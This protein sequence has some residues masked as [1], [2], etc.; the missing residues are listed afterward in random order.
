MDPKQAYERKRDR[1]A[2]QLKQSANQP[3]ALD[4]TTS[5]L[6][7]NREGSPR[8]KLNVRDFNS[9][10]NINVSEQTVEVEGMTTYED[11]VA[12]TLKQGSMPAVVPQLKTI[13]IG[14][15][16][17]GIGIEASSF[18]YGLAHEA[19]L[20]M[21]VLTASGEVLT[22]TPTNEH[23]DLF[24]AL[25]NSYG[26][27]GYIL[28]L[29]VKTVPVKPY[30]RIKHIKHTNSEEY[31]ADIAKQLDTD[32]DF[33][34]GSIFSP[35]EM[36]ITV[37]KFVGE[38]PY[39]SDYTF[40]HIYYRSIQ[41]RDEDYLSTHDFIWR[42]DTDWFW[43]SKHFYVENPLVRR[44][45]GRDRLNSRTYTK[46]MRWNQ[47]WHLTDKI[48]K[49]LNQHTESVIQDVDVPI[50]KA[51]EFLKFLQ[52]TIRIKPIWMCPIRASNPE[53]NF[54][55]YTINKN[56]T[57]I[58]F[59]FWDTIK[60]KKELPEGYYNKQIEDKLAEI[61]GIKSLYSESFYDRET[62][63]D[64]YNGDEYHALKKKYDPNGTFLGLYEKTVLRK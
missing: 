54:K 25:P 19:V 39:T 26:S 29:T 16:V 52:T 32:A 53:H 43:T 1:V 44:L 33:V 61:G 21:D 55:L 3:V 48:D 58:N 40:K 50:E 45:F 8:R 20:S 62:F 46:I 30:V 4:K 63:Y 27:F 24:F 11:L 6:F 22:C 2:A 28:K 13:T 34:D 42:W 41:N 60:G 5:N 47:K 36:Y 49:L 37:G 17:S 51:P 35:D 18:K 7:R 9:V 15:A 57:Y 56:K 10:I 38:A 64:I 23:S 12:A 31:F 14:G 59:G